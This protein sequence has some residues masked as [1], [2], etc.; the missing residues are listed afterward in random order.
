[1]FICPSAGVRAAR[2]WHLDNCQTDWL[3]MGDDDVIYNAYCAYNFQAILGDLDK[4]PKM[5]GSV[6]GIKIDVA[7]IRKYPDYNR[8]VSDTFPAP[9]SFLNH[10]YNG[11]VCD[12]FWEMPQP[13]IDA[14]NVFFF[15]PTIKELGVR[16]QM[17]PDSANCGG[18]D[19][20]FA[21]LLYSR[22]ANMKA[23]PG[24]MSWHL[25]KPKILFDEFS[26]RE[27][28]IKRSRQCLGI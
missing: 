3:W 8:A 5:P 15:V 22:G 12:R 16:F 25:E 24:C 19:T 10:A 1:M 11:D 17:F 23:A 18:E 6:S 7:D 26:A 21:E 13:R 2:D 14:G 27:E 9:G 4:C 28:V 20:L